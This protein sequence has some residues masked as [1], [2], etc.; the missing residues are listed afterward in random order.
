VITNRRSYR[1]FKLC[2]PVLLFA[3]ESTVPIL[4]ETRDIGAD[5]FYCAVPEALPIGYRMRCLILLTGMATCGDAYEMCIEGEAHVAR[6]ALQG[7]GNLSVGLGCSLASFH[8]VPA[9][10]WLENHPNAAA[11]IDSSARGRT[12]SAEQD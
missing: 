3:G 4:S 12:P 5:G 8:V 6:I 11:S 2:L 10:T 1:R 9:T 7:S